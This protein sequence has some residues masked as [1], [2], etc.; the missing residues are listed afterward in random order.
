[1]SI[2]LAVWEG[3]LPASDEEA[4]RTFEELYE[5]HVEGE[6]ETPPTDRIAAYA[7]ALLDR[8]PDITD[9]DD[10]AVDDSPWAD[11]PLINNATGP[12]MYFAMVTNEAAEEAWP[13]AVTTARSLGLVCFDPQEGAL[14]E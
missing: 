4:V 10:D 5:R 9:L 1:M 12:F 2:A 8:Y 3:P 6:D 14:A 7:R 13:F 11:G